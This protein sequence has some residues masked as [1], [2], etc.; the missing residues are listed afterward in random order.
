VLSLAQLAP[1]FLIFEF[2]QLVACER[3]VG[4][5]QIARGADPRALGLGE[6]KAFVWIGVICLYG[7][8]MLL[9]LATPFARVH[10]LALLAL[11]ALGYALRRGCPL[12][13][14]LVILTIEGAI[15][16]GVLLSLIG[17]L[18]RRA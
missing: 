17:L 18:W 15:R 16:V 9:L 13:R 2:W 4:I 8:W 14:L 6:G 12:R 3:Y 5:K 11:T 7:L 1:V 10:G